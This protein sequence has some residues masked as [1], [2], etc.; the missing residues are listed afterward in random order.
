MASIAVALVLVAA[1]ALA[2]A[3]LGNRAFRQ[4]HRDLVA[5]SERDVLTGLPHRDTVLARLQSI[6]DDASHRQNRVA[7]LLIELNRYTTIN[8]TYGHEIGD[9]LLVATT[10]QLR[11][12]L[13]PGETLG[14]YSGPQF[15]VISP[16][17]T[18]VADAKARAEDFQRTLDV[19]FRIASDNIR[20]SASV[21]VTVTDGRNRGADD[22]IGEASVA[23]R[24]ALRRGNRTVVPYEI[25]FNHLITPAT[26]ERRLLEAFEQD[27]FWLLYLPVVQLSDYSIVGV[28][29]LLRW[30]DPEQGMVATNE[31]ISALEE[32]GLIVPIGAWAIREACQQAKSWKERFPTAGLTVT[33][34]V[35][36]RQLLQADFAEVLSSA[37][38]DSKLDSD[39]ICLEISGGGRPHDMETAWSTMRDLKDLGVQIALDDFGIGFASLDYVRRFDLDVLKV[40]RSFV[41]S[42]TRSR[43]DL[44]IVQQLIGLARSLDITTVAEGIDSQEQVDALRSLACDFGQG[45]YFSVP[46]PVEAIDR[47]LQRGRV[48]PGESTKASINW[49]GS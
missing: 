19:P 23:L 28:E 27:R 12:A 7:V 8:E 33:V 4:A 2:F 24:E 31:F 29:A 40:E 13:R 37:I 14:R 43:E 30:I 32:T 18:T 46:Q 39:D 41:K 26:A 47:M 11:T 6:L 49:S 16:E 44:A 34:N 35:S 25:S 48:V 1:G 38:S 10:D 22:V 5:A 45:Y 21:G 42:M 20:I 9:A 3:V 36:P 15:V 17:A